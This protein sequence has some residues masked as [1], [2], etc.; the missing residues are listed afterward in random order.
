MIKKNL[1]MKHLWFTPEVYYKKGAIS[2]LKY[3]EQSQILILIA[4]PVK[5][6][7]YFSKIEK[8]LKEKNTSYE[9]IT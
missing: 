2:C 6:S 1:M 4:P 3:L 8:F 5:N 7:D 9:E